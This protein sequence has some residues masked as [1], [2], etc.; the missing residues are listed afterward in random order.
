MPKV[1]FEIPTDVNALIKKHTEVDW[2]KIISD[3]LWNYAKKIKLLDSITSKSKLTDK[4]VEALDREIKEVLLKR[5]QK[6]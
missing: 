4:D 5:Y 6:A 3:T 1:T 2:N